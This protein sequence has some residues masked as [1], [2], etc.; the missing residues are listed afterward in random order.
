MELVKIGNSRVILGSL[1]LTVLVYCV[2]TFASRSDKP[3]EG[4]KPSGTKQKIY[5]NKLYVAMA[6]GVLVFL[7]N[8]YITSK[9]GA[10][11]DAA[12]AVDQPV[13]S[14]PVGI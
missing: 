1:T 6:A 2:L 3:S 11:K 5:D 8:T 13:S 10:K 7:L 9:K 12:P 14:A 4:E